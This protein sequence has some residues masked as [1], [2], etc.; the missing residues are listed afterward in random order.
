MQ[1]YE[2]A[3]QVYFWRKNKNLGGMK[4]IKLDTKYYSSD[5]TSVAP[6]WI[7]VVEL[8]ASKNKSINAM[9]NNVGMRWKNSA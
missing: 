7:P 8:I 3:R 1:V 9:H 6:Q 2:Q 4:P 5:K